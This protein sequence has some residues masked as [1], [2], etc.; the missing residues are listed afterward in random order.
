M[1]SPDTH[2]DRYRYGAALALVALVLA[3]TWTVLGNLWVQDDIFIIQTNEFAHSL[4]AALRGFGQSYWP[5]P[6]APD[7]YRPLSI[8]LF[9]VEWSLGSGSPL[10][11]RIISV[12][13][14][15][16]TTLACWALARRLLPPAPAW[17]A[18]ALFAVHPVHVEAVAVAVN[19]SEL[20]VGLVLM[21]ATARWIDRRRDGLPVDGAWGLGLLLVWAA[22]ILVKE[23]AVVLPALLLAVEVTVLRSPA[24][25]RLPRRMWLRLVTGAV[26]VLALLLAI[27]ST[28]LP[29]TKGSFT[30]E[31]LQGLNLAERGLTM[32]GVVPEWLR[33]LVWPQRLQADYS[34]Q[35][36]VGA[37][38]FGAEQL[39]GAL[40]LLLAVA[41]LVAAWR[42]LPVTAF[43]VLW[44]GI[45][46]GP[47]HNVLVPTGIVLAERTLFLGSAGFLIGALGLIEAG[48]VKGNRRSVDVTLVAALGILLV[49]GLLRSSSRQRTW[50][51]LPTYAHQLLIDA[52]YSYRAQFAYAQLLYAAG[53]KADAERHYQLAIRLFPESWVVRADL[54]DHYRL[55]GH[56]W[57]A[58]EQYAEVLRLNPYH[59][60][61][62]GSQ[63]ACLLYLGR[64]AE[65][66]DV[67]RA[68]LEYGREVDNFTRYAEVADS[69]A[70]VAAP[71]GTVRLPAPRR[72]EAQDQ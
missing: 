2:Q 1:T 52:P 55:A 6:F 34:P 13:L 35:E 28:V 5:E 10:V 18:A 12:V 47:V 26:L 8:L 33:L 38:S 43:G 61:A 58:T 37:T 64:Y 14:Y 66:A 70:A 69:A 17:A 56:C 24:I 16:A 36:I 20:V 63:V 15:L 31:G 4:G 41:I 67:A 30:A 50:A 19:Q 46:M 48:R 11:F 51:D 44:L 53:A 54:A 72:E 62:R 3:S 60:A 59:A 23:H 39:L 49:C 29:D 40:L 68:G 22:T 32:L 9:A 71:R 57:P 21:L 42:R 45:A 65:A 7:L 25:S 27:R